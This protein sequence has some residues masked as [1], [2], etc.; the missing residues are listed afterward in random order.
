MNASRHLTEAERQ[1][2][3]DGTASAEQLASVAEHLGR[4][5]SCATDVARIRQLMTRIRETG[6]GPMDAGAD[7]WPEI[8]SRIERDKIVQLP[9]TDAGVAGRTMAG[10][11]R[12]W[13]IIGGV[14]AAVVI[15]FAIPRVGQRG[16]DS[17]IG[18]GSDTP[19]M[20]LVADSVR[21]YEQ[22]ATFLLNELEMR[23]AMMRPQT[24]AAVDHDLDVI[25]KA[26]GELKEAIARDPKNAALR[27]LLASSYKQKVELLKRV[28]AG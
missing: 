8:R 12:T 21:A 5:D 13:W 27:Q 10:G 14:A 28:N 19:N 6:R 22:E 15:A 25:D 3:A 20:S 16:G 24:R 7:L 1:D 4:C 23:R 9:A 26:I 11:R 18:T 2:V 17:S